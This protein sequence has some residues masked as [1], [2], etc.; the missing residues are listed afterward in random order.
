MG[1]VDWSKQN[2]KLVNVLNMFSFLF[3]KDVGRGKVKVPEGLRKA[4]KIQLK[5]LKKQGLLWWF[6]V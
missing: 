6:S 5:K 3:K 4:K 1:R 2:H